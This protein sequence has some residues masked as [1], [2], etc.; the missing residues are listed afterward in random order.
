MGYQRI[1]LKRFTVI[2]G[3]NGV[4]RIMTKPTRVLIVEDEVLVS[5]ALEDMLQ[6]LGYEVEAVSN[7]EDALTAAAECDCAAAILDFHVHGETI[8]P[9]ALALADRGIPYAIAS[10]MDSQ[11]IRSDVTKA[12][13]LPKPYLTSDV[14]KVMA[15]LLARH[16]HS[17]AE[18]SLP[19]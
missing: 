17:T 4:F 8:D 10:G 12:P 19:A 7:M 3:M 15:R 18:I 1:D 5:M 2:R 6:E 14:E 9:V 11:D 16:R 13:L